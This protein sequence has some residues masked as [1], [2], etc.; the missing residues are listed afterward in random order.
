MP[1]IFIEWFRAWLEVWNW[2]QAHSVCGLR[3][4]EFLGRSTYMSLW[5]WHPG[6]VHTTQGLWGSKHAPRSAM[7]LTLCCMPCMQ[8]KGHGALAEVAGITTI[9]T[10]VCAVQSRCGTWSEHQGRS[11]CPTWEVGL[12]KMEG[13]AWM[14]CGTEAGW[15]GGSRSLWLYVYTGTHHCQLH[16]D[17]H[18]TCFVGCVSFFFSGCFPTPLLARAPSHATTVGGRQ[19]VCGIPSLRA[20][21]VV[22]SLW[23]LRT[24]KNQ[25]QS[26]ILKMRLFCFLLLNQDIDQFMCN[27]NWVDLL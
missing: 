19:S 3:Q 6:I 14:P 15:V 12:W 8:N 18:P 16:H 4:P 13:G 10:D 11:N 26:Y 24:K 7:C 25:S 27:L 21:F 23:A 20:G 22:Y 9:H 17:H 5:V 2:N 1:Q